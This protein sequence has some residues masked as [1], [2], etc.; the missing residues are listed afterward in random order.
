MGSSSGAGTGKWETRPP[1]LDAE[2][3]VDPRRAEVRLLVRRPG[4][5]EVEIAVDKAEFLIGRQTSEVDLVLDD[6]TVSRKHARLTMN[7]RGYFSLVDLGS[8]NGIRFSGRYVRRL[9]LIDGDVFAIGKT[10]M[11]FKAKMNRFQGEKAPEALPRGLSELHVPDPS[12]S[13]AF[14]D[15]SSDDGEDSGRE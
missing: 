12:A 3:P 10:E 13:L 4:V 6:E 15:P 11:T 5:P 9:N 1:H 14:P 2:E 8:Q 7:E